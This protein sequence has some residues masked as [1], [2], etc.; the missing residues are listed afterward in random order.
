MHERGV[1]D[2]L[3][4]S[5]SLDST[6]RVGP[7]ASFGVV[8]ARTLKSLRS[9]TGECIEQRDVFIGKLALKSREQLEGADRASV[10]HERCNQHLCR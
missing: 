3:H 7:R 9:L 8:Q 10:Q 5:E 2:N 1:G 6:F 4:G